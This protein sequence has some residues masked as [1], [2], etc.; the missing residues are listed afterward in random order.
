MTPEQAT[1]FREQGYLYLP[2]ALP[3]EAVRPVKNHV[4]NG[5]KQHKIWAGGRS[6]SPRLKDVPMFQQVGKINQLIP[7]AGLAE[8]LVPPAL[9]AL[10][11]RL[12]GGPL[13]GGQDAQLL[14]SLPQQGEWRLEGLNWHR[15]IGKPKQ[16]VLPGIQVFALLD[17]LLPHGGATLALAGSHRFKNPAQA[18]QGLENLIQTGAQQWVTEG[19]P[20]SLLE[21]TGRAGDVYLMD[22]RL[23]HTPSI[24]AT[25]YLRMMATVRYFTL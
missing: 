10:I 14:I 13:S 12:A 1:L 23:L 24:N 18:Q 2:G 11:N 16:D 9:L 15:D 22:M 19:I 25:P 8:R 6:L 4:L 7:S 3:P 21:M 5:L 20:L 17:Q